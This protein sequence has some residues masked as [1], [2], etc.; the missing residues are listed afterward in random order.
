MTGS[1]YMKALRQ[2]RKSRGVCTQC[3]APSYGFT[4]CIDCRA[5]HVAQQ[6]QYA[7]RNPAPTAEAVR[8]RYWKN[9]EL[10]RERQRKARLE[11]KLAGLCLYCTSLAAD[12]SN[13]CAQH[14]ESTR[15]RNREA[16]ARRRK[17]L[18]KK[19][20]SSPQVR[21]APVITPCACGSPRMSGA[22]CC[23]RCAYL[24]G[25]GRRDSAS[26]V[27]DAL[28][29]SDGMSLV[30]LCEAL[31]MNENIDSG[32]RTMWRWVKRLMKEGRVRRYWVEDSSTDKHSAFG[33]MAPKAIS[34]WAYC[35][36]GKTEREWKASLALGGE[37]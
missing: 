24:D 2:D 16:A 14:T 20:R 12:G 23:A 17:G 22:D 9:P 35:L 19:E 27:I 34:C 3:E 30:A 18:P 5:V 4:L 6:R 13:Y 26:R 1:E 21:S 29:G 25:V 7:Q 32:L 36:D 28:R 8:R 33:V 11:R 10:H 15:A 37:R 31:D